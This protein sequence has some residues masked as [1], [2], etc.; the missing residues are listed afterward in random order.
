MKCKKKIFF[1]LYLVE[2]KQEMWVEFFLPYCKVQLYP[3]VEEWNFTLHCLLLIVSSE[4][5]RNLIHTHRVHKSHCFLMKHS[6]IN[7]NKVSC[8]SFCIFGILISVIYSRLSTPNGNL[9][10][11]TRLKT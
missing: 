2:I 1:N 4:G 9:Q 11:E 3:A 7:Y 8:I 6:G 5:P 10:E